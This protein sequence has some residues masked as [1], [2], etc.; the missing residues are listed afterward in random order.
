M[1]SPTVSSPFPRWLLDHLSDL[2]DLP[3]AYGGIGLQSFEKAADEEL[4]A[5]FAGISA[6][7]IALCRKTE[8]LVY[9]AIAE[10]LE[11]IGD[12]EAMLDGEDSDTHE[13][14]E[15]AVASIRDV[16]S[17]ASRAVTP[18]KKTKNGERTN[19]NRQFSLI[20]LVFFPLL[21]ELINS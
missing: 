7:V 5:S 13:G 16:C 18:K 3:P 14:D 19:E 12:A 11:S 9:I 15:G 20:P 2:L 8:L 17:V 1:R 6:S 10:A 21:R 4:L